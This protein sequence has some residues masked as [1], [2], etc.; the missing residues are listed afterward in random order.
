MASQDQAYKIFLLLNC[1]SL[2]FLE[3]G[4][5]MAATHSDAE[6]RPGGT[7]LTVLLTS[8]SSRETTKLLTTSMSS[9]RVLG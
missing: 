8:S 6:L 5:K 7:S 1:S 4:L 2:V 9:S 3:L